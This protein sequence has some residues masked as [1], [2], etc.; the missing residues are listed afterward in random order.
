MPNQQT[1]QITHGAMMAAVFTVLLAL[2]VYVPLLNVVTTLFLALPIAWYSAKYHWK[3]SALFAAVCLTLSVLVGGLLAL[4]LALIHIPL[5]LMIGLSIYNQKTKLFMFMGSG[6]V[7]LLSVMLQYLASIWLLGINVIEE[8]MTAMEASY[9]QTG[10]LLESIGASTDEY[11]EMVNQLM[12]TFETLLPALLVLSVFI[13][14]W[15]LLLLLL[16]ILKRLGIEVPKFPPFRDMKLP[17]SVL[18]YYLIVIL[19]SLLSDLQLGT[20][21]YMI[22]I[23]ASVVLQFLLFLQGVSFYHFYIKQEGWPTWVTVIV[24]VLALPLQSFTSIVGIID[25][26]FDIRGWVKRAHDF[27]GK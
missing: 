11:N 10:T 8:M 2:S 3:A 22:F 9:K 27:K 21:A 12:T 15:L 25:L 1:K 18:W 26:G 16:P 7:L 20:M 23:N 14:V 17:K 6:I 4:P 13:I 19:V 24:T 5:G